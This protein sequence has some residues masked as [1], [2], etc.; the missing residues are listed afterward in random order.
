MEDQ[1]KSMEK[2]EEGN[3]KNWSERV[4]DLVDAGEVESAITLL[5]S[6]VETLNSS[7]SSDWVSQ[8]QLASALTDLANLY[9]SK[10]FSLKAHDLQSQAS[11][12][13]LRHR[14]Q[15]GVESKPTDA[16]LSSSKDSIS[17]HNLGKEAELP[18][19][20]STASSDDGMFSLSFPF[21]IGYWVDFS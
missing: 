15:I 6:I 7:S 4:E 11:V 14:S 3:E 20:T 13:K 1:K 16:A 17:E 21:F 2:D 9:S 10:G 19:Q 8:L 12:I 5:E 18:N